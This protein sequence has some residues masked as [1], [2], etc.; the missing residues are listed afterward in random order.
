MSALTLDSQVFNRPP[1]RQHQ[2]SAAQRLQAD[3]RHFGIWFAEDVFRLLRRWIN[4]ERRKGDQGPQPKPLAQQPERKLAVF[5][6]KCQF[7]LVF[8]EV[9]THAPT[10]NLQDQKTELVRAP[11]T[12]KPGTTGLVSVKEMALSSINQSVTEIHKS[13]HRA[14]VIDRDDSEAPPYGCEAPLNTDLL[15]MITACHPNAPV[16][17]YSKVDS[18]ERFRRPV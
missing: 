18:S 3:F 7:I 2:S 13:P 12:E 8:R 11:T 17:K 6:G 15:L 10:P 14:K 16:I 1:L 4:L 5:G 9:V